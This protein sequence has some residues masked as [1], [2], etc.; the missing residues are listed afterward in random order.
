MNIRR[1][2]ADEEDSEET[3]IQATLH[4][5]QSLKPCASSSHRPAPSH[6]SHDPPPALKLCLTS[7]PSSLSYQKGTSN[8]AKIDVSGQTQWQD[9]RKRLAAPAPTHAN[10]FPIGTVYRCTFCATRMRMP[11]SWACMPYEV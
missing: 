1:L 10:Y 5:N 3:L 6:R 4:K 2:A 8:D 11:G 9:S 7:P